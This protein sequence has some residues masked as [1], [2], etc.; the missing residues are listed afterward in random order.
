M[1]HIS[2]VDEDTDFP[3]V[4]RAQALRRVC[5]QL[6]GKQD[7]RNLEKNLRKNSAHTCSKSTLSELNIDSFNQ[8]QLTGPR[9][10][11]RNY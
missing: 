9:K 2:S 6:L 3:F 11:F 1:P 4:T 10:Y 7:M 8:K 5:Y